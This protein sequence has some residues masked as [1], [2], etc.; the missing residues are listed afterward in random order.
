MSSTDLHGWRPAL[1][2]VA[3]AGANP[4][5]VAESWFLDLAAP[6]PVGRT[7][8]VVRVT[9][10]LGCMALGR[11][12]DQRAAVGP[13]LDVPL[14]GTIEFIVEVG[15]APSWPNLHGTIAV[16]KGTSKLPAPHLLMG[17]ADSRAQCGRRWLSRCRP[18]IIPHTDSATLAE[19][20]AACAARL[21]LAEYDSRPRRARS[22]RLLEGF[23]AASR[24]RR[25]P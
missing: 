24:L 10:T 17:R 16:G 8:H 13:V 19:A 3:A 22:V 7:W 2:W 9:R 11:L 14:R 18:E 21:A 1:I 15:A 5:D 4:Q 6:V 25:S 23:A 12:T 20:L